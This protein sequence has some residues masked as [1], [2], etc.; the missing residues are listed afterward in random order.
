MA[1]WTFALFLGRGGTGSGRL[2]FRHGVAL[3]HLL[4]VSGGAGTE[5]WAQEQEDRQELSFMARAETLSS[6]AWSRLWDNRQGT[7]AWRALLLHWDIYT[8]LSLSMPLSPPL[9]SLFCLALASPLSLLPFLP[10]FLLLLA[11]HGFFPL[12]HG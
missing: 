5:A 6:Q 4:S 8:P 1:L 11:F 3:N 10:P 9:I 2:S 12:T 7:Q